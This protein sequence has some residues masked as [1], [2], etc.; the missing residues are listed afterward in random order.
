MEKWREREIVE[1]KKKEETIATT[2]ECEQEEY[3]QG[4]ESKKMEQRRV[5]QQ[6]RWNEQ[7]RMVHVRMRE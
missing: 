5:R 7:E 3:D 4:I 2:V 1:E 6:D